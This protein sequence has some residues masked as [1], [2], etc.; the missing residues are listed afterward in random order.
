MR[1]FYSTGTIL[2]IVLC[3]VNRTYAQ[4]TADNLAVYRY[5][6]GAITNSTAQ[7]FIDEYTQA[8]TFVKTL[9]FPVADAAGKY[10]LTGLP[11][12]SSAI[13]VEG[14]I[15]LS[16]DRN[17]LSVIGYNTGVGQATGQVGKAVGIIGADGV[18]NTSTYLSNDKGS[19][20][21][22]VI[23]AGGT[24]VWFATTAT[25][26]VTNSAGLKYVAVGT[27]TTANAGQISSDNSQYRSVLE[28]GGNLYA[29]RGNNSFYKIETMPVSG[30]N[31]VSTYAL[32]GSTAISQIVLFDTNNDAKPDLLY[33]ADDSSTGIIRKY[34]SEDGG[35]TWVAKGTTTDDGVT[36]GIK[37]ITGKMISGIVTLYMTTTGVYG[38]TNIK[39]SLFKIVDNAP[40]SSELNSVDNVSVVLKEALSGTMFRGVAFTPG[41]T[42]LPV[43]FVS[44][45]GTSKENQVD[46]IWVTASEK[47]NSHFEVLRSDGSS[48]QRIGTVQP[49]NT[50]TI[51]VNE[52]SF[53]DFTPINGLNYYKIRQV[54]YNGKSTE[55]DVISLKVRGLDKEN[56]SVVGTKQELVITVK[57]GLT[58]EG[59]FYVLSMDGKK[60]IDHKVLFSNDW[61]NFKIAHSLPV[62]IYIGVLKD[63]N[64]NHRR[65]RFLI[66]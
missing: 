20:R 12:T 24:G 5:G 15:T 56:V 34:I 11:F 6:D 64:Q 45:K 55:T 42:V 44:F 57:R 37:S 33:A 31:V 40:L 43:E 27:N 14:L 63:K 53:S 39:S 48:F 2:V 22:S 51:G 46:L 50:P 54:D 4:L 25:T 13:P 28:F 23:G 52:Y 19:P 62:G 3:L 7:V 29:T 10:A 17:Y 38:N 60:L 1:K 30:G 21:A 58:G 35:A 66:Q 61:T 26:G 9:S 18:V 59:N 36:N 49:K 16:A 8:G 65:V 32:S 47:N 41:S